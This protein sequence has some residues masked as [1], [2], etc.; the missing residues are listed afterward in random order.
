VQRTYVRSYAEGAT[1]R[2]DG[3]AYATRVR[4]LLR[5]SEL[6]A[7]EFL[8]C[9]DP[10]TQIYAAAMNA[11]E[12]QLPGRQ[13][14]MERHTRHPGFAAVAALL[15]PAGGPPAGPAADTRAGA[16][17]AGQDLS[18]KSSAGHG[19]TGGASAGQGPAGQLA[20]FAYGFHGENGQWWHDTV[21]S[22]LARQD[23]TDWADQWLGDA[24]EVAEVHVH[25]AHQGRGTGRAMM[26]RLTEGRPERTAVLSTM[27]AR[28]PARRLYRTLGFTDLIRGFAFPGATAPYA[29]MGAPLPLPCLRRSWPAPRGRAAGRYRVW[30]GSR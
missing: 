24:F 27:D 18:G 16:A 17:S 25:P 3:L 5:L 4:S 26:L 13:S 29:I 21:Q 9:L 23:G 2:G 8:A 15:P 11:P 19:L 20:A 6:T 1:K 7:D 28:T 12:L 10:L 14:I 22:G 30:R